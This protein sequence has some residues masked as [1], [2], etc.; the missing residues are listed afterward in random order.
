MVSTALGW[1]GKTPPA[2]A[3]PADALF[4]AKVLRAKEKLSGGPGAWCHRV[5]TWP[6]THG[7]T[8]IQSDLSDASGPEKEREPLLIVF[9]LGMVTSH[10]SPPQ[11]L[12]I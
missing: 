11:L 3:W 8:H 9:Q 12:N 5:L 1:R 10:I 6:H 4:C 2:T 7:L